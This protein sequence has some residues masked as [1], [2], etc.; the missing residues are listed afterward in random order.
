M[1]F[2][3]VVLGLQ[4]CSEFLIQKGLNPIYMKGNGMRKTDYKFTKV[5]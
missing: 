4:K 2:L 1:L 3:Q 5:E